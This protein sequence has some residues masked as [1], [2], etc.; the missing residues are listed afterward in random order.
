MTYNFALDYFKNITK[1]EIDNENAN[2]WM[3]E[4]MISGDYKTMI[5]GFFNDVIYV[6]PGQFFSNA[7]ESFYHGM[8]FHLLFNN[9]EKDTYEILPEYNLPD[10]RVDIMVRSLPGADVDCVINDLFEVKQVPKGASDAELQAKFEEGKKEMQDYLTGDYADWRGI[11]IAFRGNKDYVA[12]IV[13]I[14]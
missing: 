3:Y 2:N 9:L 4:Y 6:F 13:L 12:E 1:F 5:R 8:L 14:E 10:G 7:N 11:V